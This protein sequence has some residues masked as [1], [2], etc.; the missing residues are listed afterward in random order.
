MIGYNLIIE[1]FF[2]PKQLAGPKNYCSWCVYQG[3]SR[4]NEP[5][6]VKQAS[7]FILLGWLSFIDDLYN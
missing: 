3:P 7:T 4:N 1:D 2:P 5:E 6:N